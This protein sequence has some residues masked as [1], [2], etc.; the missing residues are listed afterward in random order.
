MTGS[1]TRFWRLRWCLTD[2]SCRTVLQLAVDQ[3]WGGPGS[4]A[5]YDRF[6]DDVLEAMVGKWDA[7]RQLD[8]EALADMMDQRLDEKFNCVAED[9]SV[10]QVRVC[11]WSVGAWCCGIT[12]L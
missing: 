6:I 12:S 10:D 5:Q 11:T 7:R 3:E 4:R 9:G 8:V 1:C 2:P